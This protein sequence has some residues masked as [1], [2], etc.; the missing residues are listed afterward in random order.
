MC[1]S[2]GSFGSSDK[3][4]VGV[5]CRVLNY[6]GVA[7]AFIAFLTPTPEGAGDYQA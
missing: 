1:Y 6:I 4:G 2:I 3:K 7:G 5:L